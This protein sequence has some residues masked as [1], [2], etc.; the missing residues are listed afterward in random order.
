MK[1]Q[2]GFREKKSLNTAIQ[3]FTERIQ[4]AL[5]RGLQTNGI[6]CDLTKACDILNH[7]ILLDKI[8]S[9]SVNGNINSCFQIVPDRLKAFH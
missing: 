6:F 3:S 2:N 7:D 4:E 5:D 9:H 8:N 1:A